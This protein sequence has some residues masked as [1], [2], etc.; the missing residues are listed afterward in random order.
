MSERG[1]KMTQMKELAD[2][3]FRLKELAREYSYTDQ[4][5]PRR[6]DIENEI[7][8]LYIQRD[9]LTIGE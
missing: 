9:L 6:A 3:D 8:A 1:R 5:D 7:S 4:Q 2:I